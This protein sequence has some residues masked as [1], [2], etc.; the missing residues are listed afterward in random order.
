[1]RTRTRIAHLEQRSCP[2]APRIITI[3]VRP[4]DWPEADRL[5]FDR[6]DLGQRDAAIERQ[7]G[8]RPGPLT[9]MIVIR[10]SE[11]GSR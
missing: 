6:D 10:R 9:R 11:G 1:M 8:Q 2:T 7:T 4:D 3:L 5:A